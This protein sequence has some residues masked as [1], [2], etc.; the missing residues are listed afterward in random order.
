QQL[1]AEGKGTGIPATPSSV[2]DLQ[3]LASALLETIS[4]KTLA[5]N[6]QRNTNKIL[7]KRVAELEKKLKTLEVAGFWNLPPGAL[8][9]KTLSSLKAECEEMQAGIKA[10]TPQQASGDSEDNTTPISSTHTSPLHKANSTSDGESFLSL[11]ELDLV[12]PHEDESSISEVGDA[13]YSSTPELNGKNLSAAEVD[14]FLDQ[15]ESE[16]VAS[17]V[18]VTEVDRLDKLEEEKHDKVLEKDEF[19]VEEEDQV[20]ESDKD[21]TV[22][23]KHSEVDT[24]DARTDDILDIDDN[25]NLDIETADITANDVDD[26]ENTDMNGLTEDLFNGLKDKLSSTKS[27][28]G[29]NDLK[30]G[31]QVADDTS[32][33]LDQEE[34]V[35]APSPDVQV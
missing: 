30:N 20:D 13:R 26:N 28:K 14:D 6:H 12:S 32:P 10:L 5:L 4:D 33:L 21:E 18:E 11:G 29:I 8:R 31:D 35:S 7:G 3:S 34:Q 25:F 2:A 16:A 23:T 9:G 17:P 22:I 27:S 1:L 19:V 15:R 24:T